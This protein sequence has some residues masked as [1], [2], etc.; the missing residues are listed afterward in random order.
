MA[1]VEPSAVDS[2]DLQLD[3]TQLS[4]ATAAERGE[5]FLLNWV[6]EEH[7][8]Q[9]LADSAK[10]STAE[11]TIEQ[12]PEV[13]A[14]VRMQPTPCS[15]RWQDELRRLQAQ[16]EATLLRLVTVVPS[17]SAPAPRPGRPAR[18]LIARCLV[19]LFHRG[20]SRSLFDA[21]QSLAR[22]MADIRADNS[23]RVSVELADPR[24][25]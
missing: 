18:Q 23:I 8:F 6:R 17:Q 16:T 10:L 25:R 22:V 11:R 24:A 4:A 2:A 1:E 9:E 7:S 15:R 20:E 13:R 21:V 5:L 12:L 3:E 14:L 19:A